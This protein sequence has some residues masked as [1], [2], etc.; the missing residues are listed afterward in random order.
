MAKKKK[1]EI[2]K[3]ETQ[4]QQQPPLIKGFVSL[5]VSL[6]NEKQSLNDHDRSP[7]RQLSYT[8]IISSKSPNASSRR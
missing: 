5:H 6:K 4:Q 8:G 7:S 2:Q 1:K 3:L